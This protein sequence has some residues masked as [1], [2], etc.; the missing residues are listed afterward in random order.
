MS[1]LY[2]EDGYV[3][4]G[5]IIDGIEV[6]WAQSI[7]FVPKAVLTIIQTTPT[8]IL[9]LDL[10]AF[11]L[12]L[13]DLEDDEGGRVWTKT[14]DH[15]TTVTVGGVTLARVI[16]IL[17]PYT[18]TFEDGQ[19]AVNL[20]GANSNVGDRVNVNNVSVRSANSAGLQ[21]LS[22]LLASAY[23]GK[24]VID[25]VTGQTG[26]STPVGTFSSPVNNI[27]DAIGIATIQGLPELYFNRAMTIAG[28]DLSSG[29]SLVGGSPFFTI[30]AETSADLT[31]CS[32]ENMTIAG[33]LDG[34]NV[35]RRSRILNITGTNGL[36]NECLIGGSIS[37]T[38]DTT[39]SSCY[40]GQGGHDYPTIYVGAGNLLLRDFKGSIGV[41]G[42]TQG[43]HSVGVSSG[44]RIVLDSSNT[45]GEIYVRGMPYEIINNTGS[46]CLVVIETDSQKV[47]E[48]HAL[49]GL[50]IDNP[51]T[52]TTSSRSVGDI[53]LVI[54]GDGTT[55]STVTR[56]PTIF[57]IADENDNLLVDE[58][59]NNV[60]G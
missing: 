3:E 24:V 44:G 25:S 33:E 47:D 2:V 19:Y 7:I 22:T 48:L 51:M 56:L 30:T 20:V 14:H 18:I 35:V 12:R 17:E 1:N 34:V 4:D 57:S 15:N 21:D 16:E 55:T 59:A 40:S 37:I 32:I 9:Q 28:D 58:L 8:E 54:S 29:Y 45:G 50:D 53:D 13:R 38:G 10:N 49:Q 26:T 41:A 46:G 6:F 27:A 36:I 39:I 5:Y 11:H 52:V 42:V 23:Q 43:I 31:N 60:V